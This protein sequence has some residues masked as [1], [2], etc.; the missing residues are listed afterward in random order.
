MHVAVA[1]CIK[2]VDTNTIQNGALRDHGNANTRLVGN[3][4][5]ET[6]RPSRPP[7]WVDQNRFGDITKLLDTAMGT[8]PPADKIG[9]T[10]GDS[11]NY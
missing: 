5:H 8:P 1:A 7:E 2:E 9:L 3:R 4:T 6:D 11:R 10:S